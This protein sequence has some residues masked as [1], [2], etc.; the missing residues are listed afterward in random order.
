MHGQGAGDW[1]TLGALAVASFLLLL[2]D[3][4]LNVVLP[5]VRS[6][7]G[8]GLGGLEWLVNS[9]TLAL[10]VL[11]LP[12][13]RL[14]DRFGAR[15]VFL[16]GLLVFMFASLLAGLAPEL[17]TLLAARVAQGAG[18]ALATP[19]AL[20]VI[21]ESFRPG[22]RG[23]ALGIWTAAATSALAIG[24]LLGAALAA[25]GG[26]RAVLLVNVPASL[27]VLTLSP[28]LLPKTAGRRQG[29]FDFPGLASSA[30]GLGALLFALSNADS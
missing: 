16:A 14:V 6:E 1:T 5:Q 23:V 30:I 29:Q 11:L 13:G 3:T 24:P 12:A 10:A 17:V 19:A 20:A 27:A 15:H 8:L 2:G 21:T 4:S 25:V 26:W 18:A 7:L 28:R 9:Y 22:R